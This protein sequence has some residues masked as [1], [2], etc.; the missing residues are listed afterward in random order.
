MNTREMKSIA[1][2][3]RE[4]WYNPNFHA[5]RQLNLMLEGAAEEINIEIFLAY[6]LDWN[7][8][9]SDLLKSRLRTLVMG[10]VR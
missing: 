9:K 8:D 3:I 1:T 10:T 2:L 5:R 7:T 6:A 4:D